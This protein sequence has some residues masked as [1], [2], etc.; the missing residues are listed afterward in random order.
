VL[1]RLQ[2]PNVPF[3]NRSSRL[4]LDIIVVTFLLIKCIDFIKPPGG[5]TMTLSEEEAGCCQN[6]KI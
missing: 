6:L 5:G 2:H 3:K 4:A 1:V